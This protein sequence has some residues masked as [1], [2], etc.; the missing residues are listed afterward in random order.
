MNDHHDEGDK[1][2]MIFKNS[3]LNCS[4]LSKLKFAFA[5]NLLFALTEHFFSASRVFIFCNECCIRSTKIITNL[6]N[7]DVFMIRLLLF[8]P[9]CWCFRSRLWLNDHV[10]RMFWYNYNLCFYFLILLIIIIPLMC[11]FLFILTCP[12]SLWFPWQAGHYSNQMSTSLHSTPDHSANIII[13]PALA[14]S[15][16]PADMLQCVV[17]RWQ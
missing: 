6:L 15:P 13:E 9:S 8:F 12:C 5:V 14:E 10:S 2:F 3:D 7:L 4:D 1:F 17:A 16:R 11:N